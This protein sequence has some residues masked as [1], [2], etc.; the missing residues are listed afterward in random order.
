MFPCPL[1]WPVSFPLP[2]LQGQALTPKEREKMQ[3]LILTELLLPAEPAP[4]W[5]R[6]QCFECSFCT[7]SASLSQAAFLGSRISALGKHPLGKGCRNR[8]A[9]RPGCSAKGEGVSDLLQPFTC[10]KIIFC[11]H[12]VM[13]GSVKMRGY[14]C[15][16]LLGL[17]QLPVGS[18]AASGACMEK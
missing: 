17:M 4:L 8:I 13:M 14:L 15:C 5:L 7:C 6:D 16:P 9:T 2:S 3:A 10:C 18:L 12:G 11:C 1:S